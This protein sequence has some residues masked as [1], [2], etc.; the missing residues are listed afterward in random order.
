M[1]YISIQFKGPCHKEVKSQRW[2]HFPKWE[3][4]R[5]YTMRWR[6][7]RR[8]KDTGLPWRARELSR[9][10]VGGLAGGHEARHGG[11]CCRFPAAGKAFP[12]RLEEKFGKQYVSLERKWERPGIKNDHFPEIKTET[13]PRFL[14]CT[15]G[16]MRIPVNINCR[17]LPIHSPIHISSGFLSIYQK[18][19]AEILFTEGYK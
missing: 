14:L 5:Y 10:G 2:L 18:E 9:V 3:N 1:L 15:T 8:S 19:K 12:E 4:I 17:I 11:Q 13:S 7:R 16:D 6:E